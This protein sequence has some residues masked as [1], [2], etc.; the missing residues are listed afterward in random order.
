[1]HRFSEEEEMRS[2]RMMCSRMRYTAI[3][4]CMRACVCV[5]VW[6]VYSEKY[7]SPLWKNDNR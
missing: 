3:A 6:R 1:M 5:G 4:H 7:F 2:H